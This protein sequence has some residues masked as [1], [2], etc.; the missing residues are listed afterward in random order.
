MQQ[1]YIN[2]NYVVNQAEKFYTIFTEKVDRVFILQQVESE[3]LLAFN[4]PKCIDVAV[5]IISKKFSND[6]F[7]ENECRQYI[8]ELI[9]NRI[10]V[11]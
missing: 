8:N 5:D 11:C 1:Y 6:T 3:I 10:L 9:E 2:P 7:N 4:E